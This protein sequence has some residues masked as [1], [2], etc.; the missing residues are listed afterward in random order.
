MSEF[1]EDITC[2]DC[3][4]EEATHLLFWE[5]IYGDMGVAIVDPSL[6]CETCKQ[7]FDGSW[8]FLERKPVIVSFKD[9][10][11]IDDEYVSLLF[12]KK[13]K[14]CNHLSTQF[15][16]QKIWRAR[17]TAKERSKE[18]STHT[19][20]MLSFVGLYREYASEITD[21]PP[22]F[23]DFMA[24]ATVGSVIGNKC[25]F[26]F[27]DTSIYP[28]FWLI[29]LAPSSSFRK[30]TALGIAKRLLYTHNPTKI[31]PS[32]FSHE[33]I[34]ENIAK[35]PSGTFYFDEFLSLI[36]LLSRDY[37]A[38]TKSFLTE[39]YGGIYEYKR[40]TLKGEI[41]ITNPAISIHTATTLDWFLHR[42]K[43]EDLGGGFIPRFL[44][45]PAKEKT[46]N[47]PIPPMADVNK[48]ERLLAIMKKISTLS[49]GFTLSPE[50]KEMHAKWYYSNCTADAG[51]LNPFLQ[52]LQIYILKIAMCLE[53][54][55]SLTLK[56]SGTTMKKAIRYTQYI[57][58]YLHTLVED[59]IAFTK[60][61]KNMNKLKKI[62]NKHGEIKRSDLLRLSNMSTKEFN[63]AID[64]LIQ[65]E[66][67]RQ[68]KKTTGEGRKPAT[69]YARN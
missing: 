48:R 26:P 67:V 61:Q 12:S 32:E 65:S 44:I 40:Q 42:L 60:A 8:K 2:H 58:N 21:A 56:I 36:G 39:M 3:K 35:Q 5:K 11:K 55:T 68:E 63:I 7:K 23:H 51:T 19:P 50:A 66:V 17:Y 37:M 53:A 52:R 27:G 14:T 24:I 9:L 18:M 47:I 57:S 62:I 64:T 46:R 28:N 41:T 34:V 54:S 43:E 4:K 22:E 29:L 45:I 10:A 69:V 30:S 13:G 38:G 20:P 16:R 59:E 25:Y 33:R 15:W 49:G 6:I 1:K 31:Y